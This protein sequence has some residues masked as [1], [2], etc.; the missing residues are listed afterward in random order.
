MNEA[1]SYTDCGHAQYERHKSVPAI[2]AWLII[3][4]HHRN[5]YFLATIPPGRTP[6]PAL[7]SGWI[8]KADNLGGLAAKIGIDTPINNRAKMQQDG[9]S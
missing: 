1:A 5:R 4:S 6:K 2:S 3:D 8:K 7:E 9:R